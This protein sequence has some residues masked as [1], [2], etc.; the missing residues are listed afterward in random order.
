M[1]DVSFED[2]CGHC[3]DSTAQGTEL[4]SLEPVEI[5]GCYLTIPGLGGRGRR[6]PGV[7][8]TAI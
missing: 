2:E 7:Y 6:V 3:R 1:G 8:C 5:P 4:N